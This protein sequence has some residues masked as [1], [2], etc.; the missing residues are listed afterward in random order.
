MMRILRCLGY[1]IAGLIGIALMPL[2]IGV[3]LVIH[4][5]TAIRRKPV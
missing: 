3:V 5:T 2:L 4:Y 1:C